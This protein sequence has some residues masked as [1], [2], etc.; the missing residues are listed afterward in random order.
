[1]MILRLRAQKER[2]TCSVARIADAVATQM[3]RGFDR[4][5]VFFADAGF[6][7]NTIVWNAK[8]CVPSTVCSTHGMTYLS[9]LR[10]DCSPK[11]ETIQDS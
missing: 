9:G 5:V 10:S 8:P 3:A 4:G 11:R 1:M 6:T 2:L 7:P